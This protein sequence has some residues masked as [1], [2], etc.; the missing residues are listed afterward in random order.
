[1][2]ITS[3]IMAL[4]V[5]LVLL[6]GVAILTVIAVEKSTM[7]EFF[8]KEIE[9][10]ALKEAEKTARDIYLMCDTMRESVSQ[11]VAANLRVA[12][13]QLARSG[14]VSLGEETVSWEAVNQFT[15]E[16]KRVDLPKLL[17]GGEWLGQNRSFN[18]PTAL[19]DRVGE[20]VGGT[21]TVFQRMNAAG[22]MLRV[23]TNVKKLDGDR[24]IGTYIPAVNADGSPS[25][26]IQTVLEGKTFFGRAFVVNAW[27]VTGYQPL[28]DEGRQNVIGI[29]YFGEKQENIAGL[30]QGILNTK[31]GENGQVYVLGADG[32]DKG[33]YLISR[34]TEKNG[35]VALDA[36]DADGRPYIQALI[37]KAVALGKSNDAAN[38]PVAFERYSLKGSESGGSQGKIAAITYFEPWQWII[39]AEL[40]EAELSAC[41]DQFIA[42]FNKAIYLIIGISLLV[43]LAAVPLAYLFARGIGRPLKKTVAMLDALQSGDLSQRLRMSGRDEVAHMAQALDAFADNLQNEILTAFNKLAEGDFTFEAQGLIREPL[44]RANAQLKETMEQIQGSSR[45]IASGAAQVSDISQTLSQG[46]TEQASAVEEISSSMHEINN[47]TRQNAE[48]AKQASQLSAQARDAAQKGNRQMQEMMGAMEDINGSSKNIS[49]I[50]KTIDEI[51]F[52]TNLLALNAAVEAARAGQHGKGFAVVAEEVRNL[53]ARSAKAAHETAELIEGSVHKAENGVDIARRT[54]EALAEILTGITQ[55]SDLVSAIAAGSEEQ[56]QGIAQVNLG[57]SQIENVTQGNTA[58]AEESAAAAEE[59]ASQAEQLKELLSRFRLSESGYALPAP[60]KGRP[61]PQNK[62]GE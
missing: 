14:G 56:A 29:L 19:V 52:Q 48:H 54:A 44:A 22:D 50:I 40:N 58:N 39:V 49:K 55:T 45:Q 37:D 33:R 51:A 10:L 7:Q 13:D 27:Y 60:G 57:L 21:T 43:L 4:M 38:I 17:V 16:K 9:S 1:M 59:L 12:D 34:D 31:V 8:G 6:T 53:A 2:N 36:T 11:L 35:Q 46:A 41:K 18:T 28:W 61:I 24:A 62:R 5:G 32:K 25:K 20:L 47:Q 42:S 15:Q 3:K 26:I 30:R 23:A